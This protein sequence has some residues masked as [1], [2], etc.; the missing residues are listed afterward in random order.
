MLDETTYRVTIV[1]ASI[2]LFTTIIQL[3]L[4]RW[5]LQRWLGLDY[6][7]TSLVLLRREIKYLLFVH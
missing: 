2:E 1:Y 7:K 3:F 6:F 5:I 4:F